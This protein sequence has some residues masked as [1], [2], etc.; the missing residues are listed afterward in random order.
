MGMQ[1][2]LDNDVLVIQ[3][4]VQ[5]PSFLGELRK[6]CAFGTSSSFGNIKIDSQENSDFAFHIFLSL[7]LSLFHFTFFVSYK[8]SCSSVQAC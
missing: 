6:V 4:C 2:V 3:H 1:M 8:A 7:S 5:T